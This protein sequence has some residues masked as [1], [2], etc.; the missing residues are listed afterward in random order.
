MKSLF[1]F[2]SQELVTITITPQFLVSSW[3]QKQKSAQQ[4]STAQFIL[5]SYEKIELNNLEFECG[6]L[7]NPTAIKNHIEHF[8]T[9]HR[10]QSA[11]LA[12]A[13]N[14][15]HVQEK[16]VNVT[17]MQPK[18][19]E[20]Y[21]KEIHKCAWD[22][23]YVFP[24]ENNTFTF[25]VIALDKALMLQYHLFALSLRLN[26]LALTTQTAT[27]FNAYKFMQGGN[28]AYN[29]LAQE[30]K[31]NNNNVSSI[32]NPQMVNKFVSMPASFNR[33]LENELPYLAC[34]IG[35]HAVSNMFQF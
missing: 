11:F 31:K 13:I 6:V 26:L 7:Y 21:C 30:M 9:A 24:Q 12:I 33:S 18:Q 14:G 15:P 27:L 2:A 16:F 29:K 8:I 17:T 23:M 32:I 28:F 5:K 25:Y 20:L 19:D 4:K 22:Y 3:L 34:A 10:L 1:N 35:L